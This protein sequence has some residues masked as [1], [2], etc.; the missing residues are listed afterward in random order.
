MGSHE[1]TKYLG[2]GDTTFI[3]Y[4]RDIIVKVLESKEA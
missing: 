4:I 2:D 1:Q 3:E